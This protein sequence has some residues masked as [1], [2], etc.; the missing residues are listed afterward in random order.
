MYNGAFQPYLHA[1]K[2]SFKTIVLNTI[3]HGHNVMNTRLAKS[4]MY[5]YSPVPELSKII[6]ENKVEILIRLFMFVFKQKICSINVSG[7]HTVFSITHA[8]AAYF[9]REIKE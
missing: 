7:M 9:N 5:L 1:F 4:K 3:P 8:K 6:Q 2:F